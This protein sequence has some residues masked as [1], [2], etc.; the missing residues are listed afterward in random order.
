M[1]KIKKTKN[2]AGNPQGI[3]SKGSALY[4]IAGMAMLCLMVPLIIGFGYLIAVR[5]PA[6]QHTTVERISSSFA[7]Q[8]AANIQ[9]LFSRL[10]ERLRGATQSP[11]AL[12]AIA[13]TFG[14]DIELVETTMLDYFPEV[15]SLRIIPIGKMGTAT[16]R[17]GN[18]GLRN[19]IEVDLVRRASNGESPSPEAY[20]FEGKWLI[21]LA[22]RVSHPRL[23]DRKAVIIATITGELVE[24][25]LKAL[26]SSLGR[27][28]LQHSHIDL[29]GATK[30]VDVAAVGTSTETNYT[31]YQVIQDTPWRLAFTPSQDLIEKT[32]VETISIIAV[33][34]F[35]VLAA[36]ASFAVILV[37]FPRALNQQISKLT[38]AADKKTPLQ[39]NIAELVPLAKLLRR[40]TLR[41]LRRGGSGSAAQ[42]TPNTEASTNELSNPM[43]HTS[44]LDEDDE[45]LELDLSGTELAETD[46]DDGI[47]RHIFRAYDIR[48]IAATE[49]SDEIVTR[50]GGAIATIAEDADEQTIIVA[51]D[52][53]Q[54]SPRIKSALIKAL[55]EAGRDVIDIG[56]VPTPLL[57]F[58]TQHLSCKSGVMITGSH[59]PAEYNGLKIVINEQTIGAGGIKKILERTIEGKFVKGKGRMIREDIAPAY[60]DEVLGDIAIAVPLKVV[61]DAGN[62][63]TSVIA[64]ELFEELGCEVVPLYCEFDGEFP[65]R[66]PDTGVEDNLTGLV[67][68]VLEEKADF[69]VAFD[70]DGDRLAVV[71][72][73]GKLIRSDTLLMLFAQDVVSRNPGADV[74]FDVKCSRHLSQLITK[75][76]GRPVMWKTGHAYMKEKMLETG[77]LLG[78]EFSGHIFFGERWFGFDD[79]MYAAARLAEILSGHGESL[80]DSLKGFPASVNTPE[81]LIPVSERDKFPLMKKIIAEASFSSGKVNTIDG[82]RV[83]YTSGWGLLR[84]SNT[85]TALTARFE[86]SSKEELETIMQEFRAQIELAEPNLDI[87]F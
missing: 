3:T 31:R 11:L 39:L 84:A 54:S 18:E 62:G 27:S 45:T 85:T 59:N 34:L 74:V 5:E 9:Q 4:R 49:L 81:I 41:T 69:G 60:L 80:D 76:G 72:S 64:P 48:G 47:P 55:M 53:R 46:N 37:L 61:I 36:L 6:L 44:I 28:V 21:S 73:S 40:A 56:L 75:H 68:K 15:V 65:N 82:I 83:D 17:G 66:P 30:T 2:V 19:H 26:D 78:G 16:L 87:P 79:G 43:F 29:N 22:Y 67:A 25:E 32:K 33:M 52:G 57:Y 58:A 35:V 8:Q 10:G 12:S 70:G 20:K 71:T 24:N 63:A 38:L 14:T 13:D 23:K 51:S 86:A 42:P 50:I 77:A 7:T 1:L